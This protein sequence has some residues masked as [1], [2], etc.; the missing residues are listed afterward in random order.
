MKK[1]ELYMPISYHEQFKENHRKKNWNGL[2]SKSKATAGGQLPPQRP[3]AVV[4]Q[5][6]RSDTFTLPTRPDQSNF[7]VP[8]VD[9]S[10]NGSRPQP[11]NKPS[12][13]NSPP[14]PEQK[15]PTPM[16]K[17]AP[18][19]PNIKRSTTT[20]QR[21]N[22]SRKPVRFANLFDYRTSSPSS[23]PLPAHSSKTT[24]FAAEPMLRDHVDRSK[25]IYRTNDTYV[26]HR[27]RHSPAYAYT[28]YHTVSN[29]IPTTSYFTSLPPISQSTNPT[30][31][32]VVMHSKETRHVD[33]PTVIIHS[34][35]NSYTR[36]PTVIPTI[37]TI[38]SYSS[39]APFTMLPSSGVPNSTM[40][41]PNS[42]MPSYPSTSSMFLPNS[43]MPMYPSNSTMFFPPSTTTITQPSVQTYLLQPPPTSTYFSQPLFYPMA[44]PKP[45][46]PPP[47]LPPPPPPPPP[48][49][50]PTQQTIINQSSSAATAVPTTIQTENKVEERNATIFVQPNTIYPR[51]NVTVQLK[52][53][54]EVCLIF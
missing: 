39:S 8:Q 38:P 13:K 52:M 31:P 54:D 17:S 29:D 2:F 4:K 27:Q 12:V 50:V 22:L 35:D 7:K 15:R 14:P 33:P 36:P 19:Y 37:S 21:N 44:F 25:P 30:A 42:A 51:K 6:I 26:T 24:T 48:P 3:T 28:D 32:T 16:R 10:R 18:I 53:L 11:T 1:K 5:P 40:F 49:P 20:N 45:P 43:T 34:K 23:L 47:P 41:L 46:P 9:Q